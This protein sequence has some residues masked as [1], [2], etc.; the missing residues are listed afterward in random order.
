V[1]TA[2]A[3]VNTHVNASLRMKE[4]SVK[5]DIL[6]TTSD[7]YIERV[8]MSKYYTSC[9]CPQPKNN[10]D[11]TRNPSVRLLERPCSRYL[12]SLQPY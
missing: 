7:I 1:K 12:H 10:Q 9:V 5:H 2:Q 11:V 8:V 6:V 3:G 4:E